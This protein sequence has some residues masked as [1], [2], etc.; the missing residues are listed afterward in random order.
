MF[1]IKFKTQGGKYKL[2]ASILVVVYVFFLTSRITLQTPQEEKDTPL[3]E[4]VNSDNYEIEITSKEF[5][6]DQN[7]LEVDL[8]IEEKASN[9]LS[10]LE[11][12]VKEKSN[13]KATYKTELNKINN[14]YYVLFI[15]G[16]PSKWESVSLEFFDKN[17]KASVRSTDKMYVAKEKAKVFDTFIQYSKNDYVVKHTNVQIRDAEKAIKEEENNIKKAKNNNLKYDAQRTALEDELA[18][19]TDTE[20]EETQ[21]KINGIKSSVNASNNAIKESEELI[22]EWQDRITKLKEKKE[23]L[24]QEDEQK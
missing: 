6:T 24:L 22:E 2:F 1:K 16:L 8:I 15:K 9:I 4:V 17:N 13:V 18:Y 21:S 11:V 5:Y 14:E 12:E 20:K 19:Q 10:D 7:V 23:K 3:R